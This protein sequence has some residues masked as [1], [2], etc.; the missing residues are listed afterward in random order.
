MSYPALSNFM[1]GWFHQDFDIEGNS[2][3]EVL[4]A[5]RS[6]TPTNEERKLKSEIQ[7]LLDEHSSDLDSAFEE[8]FNPTSSH[9]HYPG[10]HA[11]SSKRYETCSIHVPSEGDT[12]SWVCAAQLGR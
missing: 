5:F 6:V 10:L 4:E 8:A 11:R 1:G 7:R 9:R 2:V 12:P 3:P